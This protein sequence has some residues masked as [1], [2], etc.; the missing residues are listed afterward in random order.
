MN[1]PAATVF[2]V[3][4][5]VDREADGSSESCEAALT[6]LG[7]LRD[8]VKQ[9]AR[10][11]G[12]RSRRLIAEVDQRFK[13]LR[14][15]TSDTIAS[16]DGG[17]KF[18][19]EVSL[20]GREDLA[21]FDIDPHPAPS[22]EL[23]PGGIPEPPPEFRRRSGGSSIG[24]DRRL[25][26]S[27]GAPAG[28]SGPITSKV[29]PH[30]PPV[31]APKPAPTASS[32]STAGAKKP[33]ASSP[34]VQP[35]TANLPFAQ[36]KRPTAGS[37]HNVS[38]EEVSSA[39][40][41]SGSAGQMP[42]SSPRSP[43][44][45]AAEIASNLGKSS[46]SSSE[47][48]KDKEKKEKD[49]PEIQMA[50]RSVENSPRPQRGQQEEP[51]D[52]PHRKAHQPRK[53]ALKAMSAMTPKAKQPSAS[54][55]V[56]KAMSEPIA[57]V[58]CE[59]CGKWRRVDMLTCALFKEET[60]RDFQCKYLLRT[61]CTLPEDTDQT[62]PRGLDY[63]EKQLTLT[64]AEIEMAQAV[65]AP[66]GVVAD[67]SS[68]E[69]TAPKKINRRLSSARKRVESMGPQGFMTKRQRKLAEDAIRPNKGGRTSAGTA[70]ANRSRGRPPSA[71]AA[72]KRPPTAADSSAAK[73][74]K[75]KPPAEE[76]D[77]VEVAP[78]EVATSSEQFQ[79]KL[80]IIYDFI[81]EQLDD[82]E[83]MEMR[84]TKLPGGKVNIQELREQV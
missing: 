65:L 64:E 30:D 3:K 56:A 68:S 1:S 31:G 82:G 9:Q 72:S 28:S 4:V 62:V 22:L 24:S 8:W 66:R 5:R 80:G 43:K 81:M 61:A 75:P 16:W 7:T 52:R 2:L 42:P 74:A 35:P 41:N 32:S 71:A 38:M 29:P 47:R 13:G 45:V 23:P 53:A 18:K 49:A 17:A 14:D 70:S 58:Q 39:R 21:D 34:K 57:Y 36:Q 55:V 33:R 44:M 15:F 25:S 73:R 48:E 27:G 67:V 50:V 69:N 26:V 46:S 78:G 76:E 12:C 54:S 51:Q 63:A 10:I 20:C 79:E 6:R 84:Y 83:T 60:G 59:A 40:K 77:S 11:C 19:F 37:S